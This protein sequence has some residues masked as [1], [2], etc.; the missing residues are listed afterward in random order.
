M[1]VKPTATPTSAHPRLHPARSHSLQAHHHPKTAKALL[2]VDLTQRRTRHARTTRSTL[3]CWTRE[4]TATR[5]MSQC[6]PDREECRSG[7][8]RDEW[9]ALVNEWSASVTW[10]ASRVHDRGRLC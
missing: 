2:R 10:P 8:R 3:A 9:A 5:G 6:A 1:V 4:D 7:S